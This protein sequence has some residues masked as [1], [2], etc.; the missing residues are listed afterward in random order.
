MPLVHG[1]PGGGLVCNMTT[2]NASEELLRDAQATTPDR[3]PANQPE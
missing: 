3:N 1:Q 2:A